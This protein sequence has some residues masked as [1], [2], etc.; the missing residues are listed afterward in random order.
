[1]PPAPSSSAR[2]DRRIVQTLCAHFSAAIPCDERERRSIDEFLRTVPSLARPF[3]EGG[4]L[5]HVTGSAIVVGG[6]GV[7]LH[8]H[9]R[10]NMWLQP[11]GHIEA[12]ETPAEA[13]AREAHEE[14]GLPIRH[15]R[16]GPWLVHLDVHPGPH[17][18]THF[19]VRYLVNAPDDDPSPPEGES[20]DAA[21]FDWD[22]AIDMV[23]PGLSGA[24]RT[25]RL[26]L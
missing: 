11:G 19:D 10:L 3:D 17:G 12:D 26:L 25:V 18:H 8:R 4:D 1:M 23:D 22:E 24:L 21:W 6:R 16:S 20:P 15:P 7:L 14:T 2:D 9:K 13:A 5:R